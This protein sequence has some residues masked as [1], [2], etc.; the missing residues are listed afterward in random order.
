[1]SCVASAIY[2]AEGECLFCCVTV[3]TERHPAL[4]LFFSPYYE[5]SLK[6]SL[7]VMFRNVVKTYFVEIR[8]A[9]MVS[10]TVQS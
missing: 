3:A 9:Y 1:M 4:L 7:F 2:H 5:V 10:S 8:I 6:R